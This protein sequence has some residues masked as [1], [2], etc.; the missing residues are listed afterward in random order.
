MIEQCSGTFLPW[1]HG[2]QPSLAGALVSLWGPG[3]CRP[4]FHTRC[5]VDVNHG[6]RRRLLGFRRP[7]GYLKRNNN[8]RLR[9]LQMRPRDTL[10]PVLIDTCTWR[11]NNAC[12]PF[13]V[14]PRLG[15][16]FLFLNILWRNASAG[17]AGFIL[18]HLYT[19]F[20]DDSYGIHRD[21]RN[22]DTSALMTIAIL[23]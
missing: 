1:T 11:D 21:L 4:F 10:L 9:Y 14:L 17:Q 15:F 3:Q 8:K 19:F 23:F 18:H 6:K 22:L 2:W 5:H 20:W 12:L 16:R 7:I 13:H